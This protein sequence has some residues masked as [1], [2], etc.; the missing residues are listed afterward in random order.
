MANVNTE[1][2]TGSKVTL[3]FSLS[4]PDGT[5]AIT[6][7]NDDEP[8]TFIVGDRTFQPGLELALFGLK[9]GDKQTLTL[10]PDVAY[11]DHDANMVREMPLSD[12]AEDM[13]PE[14]EQIIGF[15]MPN[16]EEVAGV[17]VEI[18]G[19]T[20]NV[21]FN[22]PLAGHEVVFTVEILDIGTPSAEELAESTKSELN[23]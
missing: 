10:M 12:F 17:I 20:V 11:G 21:D 6:T 18:N 15:N 2:Q 13:Q 8:F 1:I 23:S 16:G 9:K 14:V 5:P 7:F 19:D 4:L 22:H 3:H